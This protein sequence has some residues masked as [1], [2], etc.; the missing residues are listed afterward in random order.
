[1]DSQANF[2]LK[3]EQSE[4]ELFH[5]LLARISIAVLSISFIVFVQIKDKMDKE[6]LIKV[7]N[8]NGEL[9]CSSK[10][11]SLKNGFKFDENRNNSLTNGVDFFK[12]SRCSLK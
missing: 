10:V 6:E 9:V 7:F 2:E 5:S 12:I 11:V 4:K 8:S 3:K 1:M